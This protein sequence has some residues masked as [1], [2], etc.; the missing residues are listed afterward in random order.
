MSAYLKDSIGATGVNAALLAHMVLFSVGT[1]GHV[2]QEPIGKCKLVSWKLQS[3]P[4]WQVSRWRYRSR[5]HAE[6]EWGR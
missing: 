2:L 3:F 1:L 4:A 5:S 6:D